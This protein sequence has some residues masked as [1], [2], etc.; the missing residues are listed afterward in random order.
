MS[1]RA[2]ERPYIELFKHED[3]GKVRVTMEGGEPWFYAIDVATALGYRRTRDAVARHC[4]K[5]KSLMI[6]T[7]VKR[8]GVEPPKV[9]PESDVYRLIARSHKKEAE[10]FMDWLYEEVL[11]ALRKNGNYAV[12]QPA[13]KYGN[14]LPQVTDT[15][16]QDVLP[17]FRSAVE[18]CEEVGYNREDAVI[19]AIKSLHTRYGFDLAEYTDGTNFVRRANRVSTAIV[20]SN[21][22]TK[23]YNATQLGKML[24]PIWKPKEVNDELV[25]HKLIKREFYTDGKGRSAT[26]IRITPTGRTYGNEYETGKNHSDGDPVLGIEWYEEVLDVIARD[27][28]RAC[29]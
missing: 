23:M 4:K 15:F 22:P 27:V 18:L 2:E 16:F 19:Q 3:F 21:G 9:I 8:G 11:P 29:Y 6:T 7:A 28:A 12:E 25:R 1:G 5:A 17:V 20:P 24:F 10:A 26:R 13:K 14:D